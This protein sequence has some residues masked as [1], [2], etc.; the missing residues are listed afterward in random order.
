MTKLSTFLATGLATTLFASTTANAEVTSLPDR[1]VW[2]YGQYNDELNNGRKTSWL[3]LRIPETDAEAINASCFVGSGA[4]TSLL[5]VSGNVY[6]LQ[7]QQPAYVTFYNQSN[8][9]KILG[10]MIG[11]QAEYGISG[12]EI[13]ID[14]EDPLWVSLSSWHPIG[15]RVLDE[16]VQVTSPGAAQS[17]EKFLNDCRFYAENPTGD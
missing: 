11:T 14:N 12:I 7:E 6:G 8:E 5:K 16:D 13:A 2:E 15:Y 3:S 9:H 1:F 4:N 17:I 10:K